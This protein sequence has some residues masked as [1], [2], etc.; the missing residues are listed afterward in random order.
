MS[1]KLR[2]V[3]ATR[4]SAE[5]FHANTGLG[6]SLKF[7][8][9]PFME[10]L[11]YERNTVGLPKLYNRAI[12]ESRSNPA[13]LV[14][15]HDDLHFVD[16]FWPLHLMD[17]L[18][19]FHVVGVVGNRR[20]VPNQ[21]S[22]LFLDSNGTRD[23]LQ[24]LSGVVAQGKGFPPDYV[25]AF[26]PPRMEVKLLDGLFLAARSETLLSND[27]WFDERFD[28]D[29]YDLDFCRSAEARQ[30]RIGTGTIALIHESLGSAFD[31][32]RWRDAYAKYLEKWGS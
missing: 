15:L 19:S 4:E 27:L 5:G 22:W 3:C 8:N 12:R 29:F 16:F 32:P 6:R 14:F 2:L 28:F 18:Q 20:R 10:L 17:A 1:G 31:S 7:L 11:L 30:L 25:N 26:G 13:V 21:P 23:E 24:N 9:A